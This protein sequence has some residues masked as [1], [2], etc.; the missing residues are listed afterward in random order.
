MVAYTRATTCT[1]YIRAI[2]LPQLMNI[3]TD[4]HG[5][6]I[7]VQLGLGWVRVQAIVESWRID[8]G[9]WGAQAIS[10]L[11]YRVVLEGGVVLVVFKELIDGQ[12][13]RQQA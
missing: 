7:A 1:S 13:W 4:V 8:D 11:Y 2:N 3:Q 6:P 10:R 5:I 12:W 9:W